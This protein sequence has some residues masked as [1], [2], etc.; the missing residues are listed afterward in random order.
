MREKIIDAMHKLESIEERKQHKVFTGFDGYVD[1]IARPVLKT[2][3][4]GSREYFHTIKEFGEYIQSKA[5]KSCSIELHKETRKSGG[6]AFLFSNMLAAL[7]V[8]VKCIGAFGFPET[9]DIFQSGKDN[10]DLISVLNPGQCCA[11][12]FSDGKIMLADNAEINNIKFSTLTEQIGEE[13]LLKYVQEADALAFMNWSEVPGSTD[14]WKGFLETIFPKIQREKRRKI[15]VDLSD[16]SGRK[17]ED[18]FEMMNVLHGIS[19]YF[20]VILSLNSN[21][22]QVLGECIGKEELE[23]VMNVLYERCGLKYL[24]VHLCDGSYGK[25]GEKVFYIKNRY[26]KIPKVSTG[27][28]DNFNAGVLYS[29]LNGFD[30]E[31]SMVIANATSGYY[32]T[33]GQ[34]AVK[35]E[36]IQYLKEWKECL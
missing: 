28:G 6:N 18:I 14:I 21:E 31:T 3:E 5:K 9:M 24:F 22:F 8:N 35:E 27:G 13:H 20:D 11:M 25:D 34:S 4:D 36:I 32:I 7:D 16:C 12:E 33:R 15:F 19:N 1:M 30:M 17:E 23:D 2:N 29:L 10:L 26:I